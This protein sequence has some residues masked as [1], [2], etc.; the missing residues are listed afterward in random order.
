[1]YRYMPS[2]LSPQKSRVLALIRDSEA[3]VSDGPLPEMVEKEL[4]VEHLPNS[5]R[6]HGFPLLSLERARSIIAPIRQLPVEILHEILQYM[7]TP[8]TLFTSAHIDILLLCASHR[9]VLIGERRPT[10]YLSYGLQS[11]WIFTSTI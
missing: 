8:P 10:L 11:L 9:S 4:T 3:R 6:H 1:M 7:L 5:D 2:G